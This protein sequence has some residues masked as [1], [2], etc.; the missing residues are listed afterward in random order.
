[1]HTA[2]KAFT[3]SVAFA[4]SFPF[5][6]SSVS[7]E[8]LDEYW[9]QRKA[10]RDLYTDET[11]QL[12]TLVKAIRTKGYTEDKKRQLYLIFL[13]YMNVLASMVELLETYLPTTAPKDEELSETVAR[14]DGLRKFARLNVKGLLSFMK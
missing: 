4:D 8:L 1:M 6:T 13:G 2:E 9:R 12:D 7:T 14:F 11:V 3:K 10:L 5:S